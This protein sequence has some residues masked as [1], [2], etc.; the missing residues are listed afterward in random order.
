LAISLPARPSVA[1]RKALLGLDQL[2]SSQIMGSQGRGR[3]KVSV[4]PRRVVWVC[5]VRGDDEL[6]E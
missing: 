2:P 4:L 3:V 6:E 5:G 1:R